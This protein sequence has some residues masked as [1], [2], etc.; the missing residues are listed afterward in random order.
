MTTGYRK[1][2]DVL[3]ERGEYLIAAPPKVPKPSKFGATDA[4]PAAT[5]GTL[6]GDDVAR[7]AK[8][9]EPTPIGGRWL[10]LVQLWGIEKNRDLVDRLIKAAGPNR[11]GGLDQVFEKMHS[12]CSWNGARKIAWLEE[13]CAKLE[14]DPYFWPTS[15][16]DLV[17]AR[18][19]RSDKIVDLIRQNGGQITRKKLLRFASPSKIHAMLA[20]GEI[21]SL[22]G[23]AYGL[24]GALPHASTSRKVV[25]ALAAASDH[26]MDRDILFVALK[27]TNDA[28]RKA[29]KCLRDNDII[30]MRGEIVALTPKASRQIKNNEVIRLRNGTIVWG[31]DQLDLFADAGGEGKT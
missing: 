25:L 11:V 22:G 30:V 24:P 18:R 20:V 10:M 19:E 26:C 2:T 5:L 28:F 3:K 7:P 31:P 15:R 16:P 13:L 29:I 9:S 21:V 12:R 17:A 27:R 23:G 1:F 14:S 4:A 8:H 6:G